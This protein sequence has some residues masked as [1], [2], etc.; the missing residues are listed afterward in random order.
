MKPKE[1]DKKTNKAF[2]AIFHNEYPF[3]NIIINF[4]TWA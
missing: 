4:M 1:V 2:I 3:A